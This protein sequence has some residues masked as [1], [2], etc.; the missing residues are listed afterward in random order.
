MAKLFWMKFCPADYLLDTQPLSIGSR[1]IWMDL[2]CMLWRAE[3]RGVLSYRVAQWTSLLRCTES[4]FVTA[5]DEFTTFTI[6]DT[7][8]NSNGFVTLSSRRIVREENC[9][10]ST[11]L[12]VAK[13]RVTK[14]GNAKLQNS[15]PVELELELESE[16]KEEEEGREKQQL[17]PSVSVEEIRTRWNKIHGVKQCKKIEGALA[18]K[19]KRLIK[20][21]DQAW[22][23]SLFTEIAKS[24]FLTG[25]IQAKEGKRPFLAD[26]DWAT[27]PIN[28]G[29]ILAGNY[30]DGS[31]QPNS[32]GVL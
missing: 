22:W 6:C 11:R 15:N 20:L 12:R 21:H 29:K 26:L 18:D 3:P 28:L 8:T 14:V 31:T 13:H 17:P 24:K 10:K 16:L 25:K 27:G 4:E 30:D 32:R 2:I 1:G 19:I 23:E 5:L 7:V 9:R